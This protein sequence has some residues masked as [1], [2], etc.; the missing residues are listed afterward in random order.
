MSSCCLLCVHVLTIG[1]DHINNTASARKYP[2]YPGER[3]SMEQAQTILK[4][5]LVTYENA[6]YQKY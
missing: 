2:V 1:Y 5:D 6:V 4:A 3:I